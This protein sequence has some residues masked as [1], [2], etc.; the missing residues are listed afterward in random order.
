MLGPPRRLPAS[1]PIAE[2]PGAEVIPL[3]PVAA[4]RPPP[5]PAGGSLRPIAAAV[6][7][8][9]LAAALAAAS[10]GPQARAL[11]GL[12]A[13]SRRALFERTRASAETLCAG[14]RR[15]R[16]ACTSEV[17]LLVQFPECDASCRAWAALVRSGPTR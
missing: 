12:P 13:D 15:L 5:A 14:D 10:P 9:A 1:P 7:V 8:V 11:R 17:R 6:G 4:D 2:A 3:H 16:D